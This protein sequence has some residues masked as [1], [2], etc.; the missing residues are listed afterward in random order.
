M[1]KP[2]G[3]DEPEATSAWSPT[4]TWRPVGDHNL[5][6]AR[7]ID[8]DGRA[9]YVGYVGHTPGDSDDEWRG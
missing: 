9:L 3:P 6:E 4:I 2:D 1:V 8:Q 5:P 7:I